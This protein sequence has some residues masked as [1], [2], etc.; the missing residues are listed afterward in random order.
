MKT[1]LIKVHVLS[2]YQYHESCILSEKI[3]TLR[4]WCYANTKSPWSTYHIHGIKND[5][6]SNSRTGFVAF[7]FDNENEAMKFQLYV[8]K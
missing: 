6:M 4:K 7:E 2:T 1:V 8:G 5:E 3:Q